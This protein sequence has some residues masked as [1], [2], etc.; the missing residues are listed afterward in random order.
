MARNLVDHNTIH[1]L[2][3]NTQDG[4][5]IQQSKPQ[6]GQAVKRKTNQEKKTDTHHQYTQFYTRTVNLTNI[7]FSQEEIAL[8]NKGLQHSIEKPPKKYWT[9]LIM[10]TEQAI[11]K[12]DSKM[13]GP[14]R[15]LAT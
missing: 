10:E 3:T 5:T 6:I 9:N 8:L 15:I 2:Q 12:L 14:Y 11:R 4:K 13:Q 1:R 7:R